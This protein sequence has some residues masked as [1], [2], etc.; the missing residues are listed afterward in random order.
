LAHG[1]H[2]HDDWLYLVPPVGIPRK[3][4]KDIIAFHH[5]TIPGKLKGEREQ[6]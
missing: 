6:V 5:Q 1:I 3:S 4:R 2:S